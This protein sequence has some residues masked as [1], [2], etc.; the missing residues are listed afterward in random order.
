MT[1]TDH[2][3]WADSAGAYVLGAMT[4]RERGEFETHLASCPTCQ[5]DVDEL[6]PAAEAL[7]MASPPVLPPPALKDRIMAEVEREAALLASAGPAADRPPQRERRRFRLPAL[8]GWRL[9]PVAAALLI[10]GVLAGVVLTGGGAGSR[11]I[12]AGANAKVQ[13]EGD[14]ATIVAQNMSPPPEGRVYEVW[15]VPKGASKDAAPEPTNVLFRPRENGSAE[16]AI[17]GSVDD[18]ER[19]LVSDE[20]PG[21]SETPTGDVVM[22]VSLS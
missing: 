6:R 17:P 8:T 16:A 13:I 1:M 20:P 2:D 21:G 4:P 3:R 12:S 7:P 10:A 22:N 5:Q 18:I 15:V 9:A 11:T 14:K 19:V